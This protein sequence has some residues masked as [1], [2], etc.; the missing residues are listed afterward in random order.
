MRSYLIIPALDA[1]P[2]TNTELGRTI[3]SAVAML[4]SKNEAFN[5][6]VKQVMTF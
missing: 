4:K 1:V 2:A 3:V 6:Q 5:F